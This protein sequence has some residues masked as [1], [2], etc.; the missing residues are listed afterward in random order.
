M[1][2]RYCRER[3]NYFDCQ[4]PM[5]MISHEPLKTQY[6]HGC[7]ALEA[8]GMIHY[9]DTEYIYKWLNESF[10]HP[11]TR[12]V[13]SFEE[14]E[15]IRFKYN[16]YTEE[17][18][19]LQCPSGNTED[20]IDKKI[21]ELFNCNHKN[22]CLLL[23]NIF[24][25]CILTIY[26]LAKHFKEYEQLDSPDS[27]KFERMQAEKELQKEQNGSWLVRRSSYNRPTKDNCKEINKRLHLVFYAMSYKENGE[28]KHRLL[29]HRPGY[30][31]G[32]CMSV[33]YIDKTCG[34]NGSLGGNVR[35]YFCFADTLKA[36]LETHNLA[37]KNVLNNYVN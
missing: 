23:T 24:Y 21:E 15:Y 11:L 31:W 4:I 35:Y 5:D 16:A 12:R 25:R 2:E 28:I 37:F 27:E 32:I 26:H 6:Q 9:W 22:S 30:G 14:I 3:D 19:H 33:E 10:T 13:L 7:V 36:L 34:T 20:F 8:D 1:S 17:Q 18:R 29:V